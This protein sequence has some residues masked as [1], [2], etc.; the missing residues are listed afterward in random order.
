MPP[1]HV[2]TPVNEVVIA[3]NKGDTAAFLALFTPDGV[4]DDSGAIYAGLD[5]IATW[6][7]RELIG[8]KGQLTVTKAEQKG[9]RI[10]VTGDWK[11]SFFTGPSRMEFSIR[12]GK[13][14][15]LRLVAA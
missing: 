1:I 3:I 11:S 12:G 8:A 2:P 7:A 6:N 4:V 14:T 10:I 5:E 13:V 9:S 15:L